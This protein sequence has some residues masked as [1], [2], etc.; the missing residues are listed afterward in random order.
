MALLWPKSLRELFKER[1][2]IPKCSILSRREHHE[3]TIEVVDSDLEEFGINHHQFG[4]PV[5]SQ[6]LW[7][8]RHQLLQNVDGCPQK[9]QR[10]GRQASNQHRSRETHK[11]SSTLGP[12]AAARDG[13]NEP[14]RQCGNPKD[15]VPR[16]PGKSS[17]DTPQA[18]R[19]GVQTPSSSPGHPGGDSSRND[20][21]PASGT[22]SPGFTIDPPSA[23]SKFRGLD[24][25]SGTR[26][27][28]PIQPIRIAPKDMALKARRA[29]HSTAGL[30]LPPVA[31]GGALARVPKGA[32]LG[33]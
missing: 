3:P 14:L 26:A 27:Q 25:D 31:S 4:D 16:V 12:P 20:A 19:T 30:L 10:V 15:G 22:S 24:R 32:S 18:P 9:L 21:Q 33:R 7:V 29:A 8:K 5:A 28:R 23:A 2:T 11:P 1:P 13:T 17:E 6:P